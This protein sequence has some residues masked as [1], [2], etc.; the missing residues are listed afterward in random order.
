MKIFFA[1]K[2]KQI[3]VVCKDLQKCMLPYHFLL[4][5][6]LL[7]FQLSVFNG[8]QTTEILS[9]KAKKKVRK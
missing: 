6:V 4:K 9:E 1:L 7:V 5:S 2:I 8:Q 3:M